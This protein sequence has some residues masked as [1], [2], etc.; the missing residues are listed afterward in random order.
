MKK[1]SLVI[2]FMAALAMTGGCARDNSMPTPPAPENGEYNE[3]DYTTSTPT[4]VVIDYGDM[5]GLPAPVYFEVYD[6]CPVEENESGTAYVKVESAEPLYAGYTDAEGHFN[7]TLELPSYVEKAYVYTPAF[8]AQTLLE[9]VRTGET[10]TATAASGS[11][12][13]QAAGTT[14]AGYESQAVTRDGWLTWLGTYDSNN[15]KI[16]YA[17]DG[18]LKV[19][20]YAKL[21]KAHASVFDTTKKCPQEYRSSRDLKLDESAEVVITMLGGNTCWNSSMGYYYYKEGNKPASLAEANVVMIF[22]NTQDGGWS[23][24]NGIAKK[25]IGV[26]RGTAVQLMY[27][28]NIAQKS[29]EGATSVFPEG[30]RIGFVLATNAW[31]KRIMKDDKKYRAA[32]SDGLSVNNKGIAY[33]S[34]RTAVFRYTDKASGINSVLFSFEDHVNDENFSDVVFTMTSN[35]VDAVT[36]IPTVDDNDGMKT[37]SLRK[38]V[39]AFEDLWPSRGDYDMNDVLVRSD[40]EKIFNEKG[41][42]EESF[43]LKTFANYAGNENGLAVTL[44]GA[45]ASANLEFS[46]L[47]PETGEFEAAEFEREGNVVLLTPNVKEL[48]GSTYKITAKHATPVSE[49]KAG[50]VKPFIYRTKRDGVSEGRR[51]EVHIPY[52]VPTSRAEMSFFGTGDDKSDPEKG[53]YYVRAEE[54]P[55]AFFL[56]GATDTDISKLLDPANEKTP[57]D[58]I[59]PGYSGWVSSQGKQNT[60]WY[61]K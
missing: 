21:F 57:V 16:G 43:L 33:Q 11:T 46:V 3:Y 5:G 31:T 35:P 36:D 30:Y 53:V 42:Y 34:P 38:G 49:E 24:G 61:K 2:A 32:T 60:D 15:G 1:A 14:R 7:G 12:D 40:Y 27:Y 50:T 58:Q 4:S 23:N 18:V 25:Y 19:K 47:K 41:I 22:P 13:V 29:P 51:W 54:Y 10:L 26:T 44:T 56:S 48:M 9:A 45:A 37:A 17:Y 39:Y 20:N 52:E 55:F 28:P 59:Y 6:T 8:Y